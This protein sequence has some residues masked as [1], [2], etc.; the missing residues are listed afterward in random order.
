MSRRPRERPHLGGDAGT[1]MVEFVLVAAVLIP[2][3][4]AIL[5]LGLVLHIRN[6][7]SAE[8]AEGA[9]RAAAADR[10]PGDGRDLTAALVAD[11]FGSHL[12]PT[13]TAGAAD[14]G[15]IGT[16]W[17]RVRA[18]MPL[19][20]WLAGLDGGIDVTVHAVEEGA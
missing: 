9:R 7:L 19:A 15:G 10:T 17:V 20:G 12:S 4:L 8:A 14:V 6:T 13:V 18:T 16:V 3:I 11:S 1:A 5:Q 2:L